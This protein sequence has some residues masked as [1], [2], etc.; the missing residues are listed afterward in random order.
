MPKFILQPCFL[1]SF[2]TMQLKTINFGSNRK[3]S[4]YYTHVE[5]HLRSGEPGLKSLGQWWGNIFWLQSKNI[6]QKIL[7][8][9]NHV[10][11]YPMKTQKRAVSRF[12]KPGTMVGRTD[13]DGL[14]M[15]DQP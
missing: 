9:D 15:D 14:R 8:I 1:Q 12:K 3:I 5:D 13:V 6:R 4:K 2:L 10:K 7:N 11:D